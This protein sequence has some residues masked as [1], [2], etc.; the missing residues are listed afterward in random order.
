MPLA[1]CMPSAPNCRTGVRHRLSSPMLSN[2]QDN[3]PRLFGR[4]LLN[5]SRCRH[6]VGQRGR[7]FRLPTF[8]NQEHPPYTYCILSAEHSN[9]NLWRFARRAVYPIYASNSCFS[10]LPVQRATCNQQML[11]LQDIRKCQALRNF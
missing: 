4:R 5:S 7:W 11:H 9:R 10:R 3:Q 1:W 8:P 2:P 6:S